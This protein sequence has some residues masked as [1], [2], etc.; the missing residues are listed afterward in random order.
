MF[1]RF[2]GKELKDG[3]KFCANCGAKVET[4]E[5]TQYFSESNSAQTQL[6]V[7]NITPEE[8]LKMLEEEKAKKPNPFAIIGIAT[9]VIPVVGLTFSIIGL[10]KS[11][12]SKVARILSSIGVGISS[13]ILFCILLPI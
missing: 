4:Y 5:K 9:S 10:A 7:N 3:V 8:Y 1:C 2:C 13:F 6:Y 11:K 12:K